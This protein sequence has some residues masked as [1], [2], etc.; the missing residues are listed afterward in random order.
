MLLSGNWWVGNV[1]YFGVESLGRGRELWKSDGTMVGTVLVKDIRPGALG[2]NLD[3]FVAINGTLF[4]VADDGVHGWELWVAPLLNTAGSVLRVT[5]ASKGEGNSGATPFTFVVILTPAST[6]PVTVNFATASR[7]AAAGTD[8]TP[9]AGTL[10]F[11]P[12][13][14]SKVVTVNVVGD[15]TP[16]PNETF[17]VNLSVPMGATLFDGQGMGTILN[18]DAGSA[19]QVMD[20]AEETLPDEK[21][22]DDPKQ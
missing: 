12:G 21:A 16:E 8:Y 9:V 11:T 1:V 5:D 7:T 13:Q 3:G 15:T 4:F 20:A 19:A 14:T 6:T 17:V 18:D 2:S 10:T 22:E